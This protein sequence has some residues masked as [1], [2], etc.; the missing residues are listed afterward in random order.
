[1]RDL[2]P[3]TPPVGRQPFQVRWTPSKPYP[4]YGSIPGSAG[5]P[6]SPEVHADVYRQGGERFTVQQMVEMERRHIDP[7]TVS[8]MTVRRQATSTDVYYSRQSLPP[9][10]AMECPVLWT[11]RVDG[12]VAVIAPSG[13]VKHVRPDGWIKAPRTRAKLGVG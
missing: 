12:M 3:N 9:V 1:M 5:N 10:F 13:E 7:A 2:D 8:T 6:K 4:W 11:R